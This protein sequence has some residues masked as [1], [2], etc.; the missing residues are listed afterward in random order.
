MILVFD[1]SILVAIERG[2]EEVLKKLELLSEK[3]SSSPV[4]SF[5]THFEFSYGLKKRDPKDIDKFFYFLNSFDLLDVTVRT[6]NI[7]SDLKLKY[8][9]KG[10]TFS[11]AD[12]FIASQVI[13][14]DLTLVTLDRDFEGISE[15]KKIIL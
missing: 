5:I 7:L 3:Y 6:S 14:N 8:N 15:L 4:L 11:L 13:E 12:L 2:S 9:K 10:L 1:T